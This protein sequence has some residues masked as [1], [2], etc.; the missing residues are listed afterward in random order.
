MNWKYTNKDKN[1][2]SR[3]LED[4]SIES[5]LSSTLEGVEIDQPDVE[6][7]DVP[8]VI[9]KFQGKAILHKLGFLT[10]VL[11]VIE[12]PNTDPLVKLAWD[13]VSEFRRN[14]PMLKSLGIALELTDEQLDELFIE[15][16]K[17]EV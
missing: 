1:V 2:A 16:G 4:G 9:S 11:S 3:V 15:A 14:S 5:V 13:N 12:D 17:I 7:Q 10:K 8:Q 6:L